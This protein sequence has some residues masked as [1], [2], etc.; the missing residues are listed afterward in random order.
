MS[1]LAFLLVVLI[2]FKMPD[3]S[4]Q[5]LL[6]RKSLFKV[7]SISGMTTI[8]ITL[9]TFVLAHNILYTYIGPLSMPSGMDKELSSVLLAF[10]LSS[11]LG[12]ALIGKYVDRMLRKLML[13]SI[14]FFLI[15]TL[16][17][18]YDS[19]S[20]MILIISVV[21]WG[22]SYGGSATRFQTATVH[23][24]AEEVDVAQASTVVAWNLAISGGGIIGGILLSKDISMLAY[25]ASMLLAGAF[26]VVWLANKHGF[27]R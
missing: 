13:A 15:A 16:L 3:A 14:I 10:G 24:A 2:Q 18:A 26:F 1:G 17:L 9:F 20:S 23:A 5:S 12:I 22:L 7:L 8:L 19:Q 27:S 25:I 11:L 4:G 21:I 6:R